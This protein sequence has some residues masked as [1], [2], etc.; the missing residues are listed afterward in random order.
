MIEYSLNSDALNGEV[1]DSHRVQTSAT[2]H[3]QHDESG[4]IG[5]Y[6]T[7][8]AEMDATIR[9]MNRTSSHSKG[10]HLSG[11]T[12]SV[13]FATVAAL[14]A[15]DYPDTG[16][17]VQCLRGEQEYQTQLEQSTVMTVHSIKSIIS[18]EGGPLKISTTV[19]FSDR[20]LSWDRGCRTQLPAE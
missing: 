7:N 15:I 18:L 6:R 12:A 1:T 10:D 8:L 5:G 14:V 4:D 20:S 11:G 17:T 16:L 19:V 3:P 9:S 13:P 2:G